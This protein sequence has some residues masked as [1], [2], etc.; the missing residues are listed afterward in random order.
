MFLIWICYVKLKSILKSKSKV[1]KQS[2]TWRL[3]RCTPWRY[4]TRS[5]RWPQCAIRPLSAPPRGSGSRSW[6]ASKQSSNCQPG[7][8]Y[9]YLHTTWFKHEVESH[10][11]LIL[12]QEIVFC[13]FKKILISI[14][15]IFLERV[16]TKFNTQ[17]SC[18]KR[19]E[20]NTCPTFLPDDY[21]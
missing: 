19:L 9:E 17:T 16:W 18:I 10:I 4:R 7:T 2:Q 15:K 1:N 12:Q 21:W 13:I 8:N 6:S 3:Y 11:F 5:F 20:Y 14:V